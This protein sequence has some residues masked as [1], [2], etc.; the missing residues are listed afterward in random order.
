MAMVGFLMMLLYENILIYRF[1]NHVYIKD[2]QLRK[3]WHFIYNDWLAVNR[4]TLLQTSAALEAVTEEELKFKQKHNFMVKSTQ[5][6][7]DGHLWISIF[8]KPAKSTFT[9]AQRLTCA[10]SLLLTTMLTNIMFYGIPTDDPEDQV[11][12][13]GGISISLS[14]IVI[15][16]ES[17]LIMF[18]INLLILQLFLKVKPRPRKHEMEMTSK[19]YQYLLT[20]YDAG[21]KL[22]DMVM[23]NMM[24]KLTSQMAGIDQQYSEQDL[25]SDNKNLDSSLTNGIDFLDNG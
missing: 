9:R 5:D 14:A 23:G 12:E 7:R 19:T 3:S 24:E 16:I 10:L 15:G 21:S 8:S 1:L 4:G 13:A 17:S 6:L 20:M 25:G 11:G 22:T 2:I 18:P